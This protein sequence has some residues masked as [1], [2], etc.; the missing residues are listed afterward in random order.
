[1]TSSHLIRE[2]VE[3]VGINSITN[4]CS[5][6]EHHTCGCVLEEDTLIRLRKRQVYINGY[7]KSAVGV[8]WVS[9]GVD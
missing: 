6:E 7:E 5:C 9:E 1:M 8:Y 2:T 3:I 4:G